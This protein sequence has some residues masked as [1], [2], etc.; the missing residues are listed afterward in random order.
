MHFAA[1]RDQIADAFSLPA[2]EVEE[3]LQLVAF[4]VRRSPLFPTLMAAGR[5]WSGET[6]FRYLV[7]LRR[8][9]GYHQPPPDYTPLGIRD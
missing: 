9:L 3:D 1:D 5:G 7:N 8:A 2:K 4:T 6:I